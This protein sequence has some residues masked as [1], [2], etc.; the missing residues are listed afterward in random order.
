M[1]QASMRRIRLADMHS[2]PWR[3]GGGR[4]REL[5]AWPQG[6]DWHWRVSV[7][8]VD[9]DGTFSAYPS[10]RRDFAVL[11]GAGVTL[12]IAGRMKTIAAGDEPLAFDGV[13]APDCRL[14]D[15]ATQDLN[16][17]CRGIAG[18]M[19]RAYRGRPWRPVSPF[20]GLYATAP[21]LL[22]AGT[23]RWPVEADTLCWFD[24]LPPELRFDAPQDAPAYWIAVG[25][26]PPGAP[27]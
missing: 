24:A 11:R 12:T 19:A 21:G 27:R 17:M 2:Q 25:T 6:D 4:T 26:L 14:V 22:Q 1:T 20:G 10:V 13:L 3:N 8:N 9:A 5:L 15:G 18:G 16:L 23:Q 7:A